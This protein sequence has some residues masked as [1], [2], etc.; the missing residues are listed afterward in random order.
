MLYSYNGFNGKYS[1]K[2]NWDLRF[3]RLSDSPKSNLVKV[4]IS[5][6]NILFLNILKLVSVVIELLS[7]IVFKL[8]A[9]IFDFFTISKHIFNVVLRFRPLIE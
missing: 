9:L 1:T 7:Y 3:L 6:I 4:R 5:S 8:N 2:Q